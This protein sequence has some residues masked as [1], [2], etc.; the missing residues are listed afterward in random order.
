MI[1]SSSSEYEIEIVSQI[2]ND[3][4]IVRTIGKAEQPSYYSIKD[5]F[6]NLLIPFKY[7]GVEPLNNG[8]F[9]V[10]VKVGY[11]TH[12]G[13]LDGDF[14][15]IIAPRYSRIEEHGAYYFVSDNSG[16]GVLD[17]TGSIVIPC[18]YKVII[19]ASKDLFWVCQYETTKFDS[20]SNYGLFGLANEKGAIILAPQYAEVKSFQEGLACVLGGGHWVHDDDDR[21][22]SYCGGRW[23]VINL[24]GNEVI[25]L[26]YDSMEF[27]QDSSL[28]KVT[29]T[30]SFYDPKT[31]SYSKKVSGYVN[32]VGERMVRD[33]DGTYIKSNPL[34]DWQDDYENGLSSVYYSSQIG[35]INQEGQFLVHYKDGEESIEAYLPS[36]FIWGFDSDTDLIVVVK[37]GEKGLY[38]IKD[39]QVLI[40]PQYD[41]LSPISKESY[42]D[43]LYKCSTNL[44]SEQQS[45]VYSKNIRIGLVSKNGETIVPQDYIS[46]EKL[47]HSLVVVQRPEGQFQIFDTEHLTLIS[48]IFDKVLKFGE[49]NDDDYYWS[50]DKIIKNSKLAI[51]KRE[52][53]YGA[54]NEFGELVVP[55]EYSSLSLKENNLLEGDGVLLDSLGRVVVTN[56]NIT[57]PLIGKFEAASMLENNLIMA[58]QNGFWGCISLNGETI[59]PFAYDSIKLA[60]IYFIVSQK[61]DNENFEY[62][63]IDIKKNEIIPF[64]EVDDIEYDKGL[65]IYKKDS[66]YGVYSERGVPIT[67]SLYDKIER[68]NDFLIKVGENDVEYDVHDDWYSERKVINWG[69]LSCTGE[70]ILPCSYK[71]I[72]PFENTSFVII[73]NYSCYGLL[74]VYGR[75]VLEPKYNEIG[76]FEDSFSIV[77]RTFEVFDKNSETVDVEAYG[78]IDSSM[79]E[80]IPCCFSQLE[81]DKELRKFKTEKG[82]KL[83]DGRFVCTTNDRR[84]LVPSKYVYCKD[85]VNNRAISVLYK[86][87]GFKYG[88]ID[89]AA[90]DILP[91]IFDSM[92]RLDNGLYRFKLNNHYGIIDKDGRVILDNKYSYVGQFEG[93]SALICTN[94]K[95]SNERDDRKRYGLCKDNG[96][97]ILSSEYEFIGKESEGFRNIMKNGIWYLYK[98]DSHELTIVPNVAYL[99]FAHDCRFLVNHGGEFIPGQKV[100]ARGGRWGYV[101][102]HARF[103]I[104]PMYDDAYRFKENRALVKFNGKWGVI[105]ISGNVII[106]FEYDEVYSDLENRHFELCANGKVYVFTLDGEEVNSFDYQKYDRDDYYDY[107]DD[108]NWEEETWYAL[109]GGQY[110]D[111]P[112]GDIDYDFLGL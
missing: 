88:L 111:Y 48:N 107:Q 12:Y 93:D 69:L 16:Y 15:E 90:Q 23:G 85:F 20:I 27:D 36:E 50:D 6:G 44:S 81:Y 32:K 21:S 42:A 4:T 38:S 24:E 52:N 56:G 106:P 96:E 58:K 30:I 75:I 84:I 29:K 62:G 101:D 74:D 98:V 92:L 9:R 72:E 25:P 79:N 77:K 43:G 28:F 19:M 45:A 18:M 13:I 39:N 47:D 89:A 34:Y 105:D 87:P 5:S 37:D 97:I 102:D 86:N 82:Y 40:D 67:A 59:I 1:S 35:K 83:I 33:V 94:L 55:I 65:F 103:V 80:V 66:K 2:E 63:V 73:K 14:E 104:K 108:T 7:H 109:T 53:K 64:T 11:W 71:L 91:P 78:V 57:V 41:D 17:T 10:F 95:I 61:Q 31:Y 60:G 22:D 68:L 112:G 51:V 26:I 46:I 54:I 99:G 110:G 76:T 70:E 3:L 100:K 49:R 8:Q